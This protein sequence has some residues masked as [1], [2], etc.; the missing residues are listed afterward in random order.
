MTQ[1]MF[2]NHLVSHFFKEIK[3][4][5]AAKI[6]NEIMIAVNECSIRIQPKLSD[7]ACVRWIKLPCSI[8]K[9]SQ[10][11]NSS[12]PD[13]CHSPLC[14]SSELFRSSSRRRDALWCRAEFTSGIK[15]VRVCSST[16]AVT[17][18]RN[19]SAVLRPIMSTM[20]CG[21]GKDRG[22]TSVIR[23]SFE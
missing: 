2:T 19:T 14:I 4:L 8:W 17:D 22:V 9:L 6:N 10:V 11:P 3:I 16:A 1:Y 23:N 5:A 20:A 7:Q 13:Y 18:R 12:N 21:G 15:T